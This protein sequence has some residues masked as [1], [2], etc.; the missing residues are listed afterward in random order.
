MPNPIVLYTDHSIN[1]Y[2]CYNFAK[3][4]G[5]QMC[6][7]NNFKDFSKSIATYGYLRGAGE[8]IHKVKKYFY[9]LFCVLIKNILFVT[10]YFV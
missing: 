1:R 7:V 9:T 8:V 10:Y 3:G 2:L 5:S 6:H 4:S